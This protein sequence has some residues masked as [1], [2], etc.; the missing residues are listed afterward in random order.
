VGKKGGGGARVPT[1]PEKRII[2]TKLYWENTPVP[3]GHG[4]KEVDG[5]PVYWELTY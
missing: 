4:V 2:F 1:K 5:S 3:H